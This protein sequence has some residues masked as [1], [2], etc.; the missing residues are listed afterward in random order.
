[1]DAFVAA[2]V[3]IAP[4]YL[5][6]DASVEKA[7]SIIH[8]AADAGARLIAFPET[9][10][11]GYPAW[12]YGK[13]GWEDPVSKD[14]F[15]ELHRNAVDVPGPATE[16]LC[17]A[18]R[19]RSVNVVMG[20]HERDTASSGGTI[21]NS[22]AFISDIGQILGV[23][24]KLIPTHAERILWGQG[25]GSGLIVAD[26]SVGKVGG[27]I[28]WEH[29]MPLPRFALHAKGEQVHVAA[30]PDAPDIEQVASRHY[31]FEGRCFVVCAASWL[32]IDDVPD[33]FQGRD[34]LAASINP[35]AGGGADG[36]LIPGGSSIIGPDGNFVVEPLYGKE[37]ILYGEI[38]LSRIHREHQ[39]MD[40]VGHY[41][42]PDIFR[43][44]ID[45]VPRSQVTWLSGRR[46]EEGAET[47]S[48]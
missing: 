20:L 25:D 41:N 34:A 5:D 29:W 31:A 2:A 23:H 24:R 40:T 28:C 14:I 38:D 43:V 45:D 27:L 32:T 13:A 42:R 36:V 3:Q 30:W 26:M 33:G 46:A 47:P 8:E 44:T 22:L 18:A 19:D 16:A 6:R 10:L 11:P 21:Y 1:M 17:Q 39:A 4:V 37:A 15:A 12:I 48:R 7:V 35:A 9:W